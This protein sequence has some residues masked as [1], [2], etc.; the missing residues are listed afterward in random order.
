MF[1]IIVSG[2]QYWEATIMGRSKVEKRDLVY[3]SLSSS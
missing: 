1:L 2:I 3:P